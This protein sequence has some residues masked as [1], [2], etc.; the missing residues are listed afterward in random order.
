[1]YEIL[2]RV[3]GSGAP[4]F[5]DGWAVVLEAEWGSD[6]F[7]RRH[8]EVA[9]LLS[10]TIQQILAL[11]EAQRVRYS[12]YFPQWWTAVVQ[13]DLGWSDIGRPARVLVA[14]ETLDHL[15]SA[16]DLLETAMRGSSAAPSGSNLEELAESCRSW[17]EIL[18][19]MPDSEL[20][21]SVRNEIVAQITHLLWL[22]EHAELF[23]VARVSREANVVVGSLTQASTML[24]GVDAQSGGRWKRAFLNL[25]AASV[26]LTAGATQLQ[27][28]IEAGSGVVK[29]ITQVVDGI[30]AE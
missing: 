19:E 12:R 1:M 24:T 22:I 16:A 14:Q 7:A 10:E 17:L 20:G 18:A 15:A 5:R 23:G 25:V 26:V 4:N 8:A 29:E 13:P 28:A 11:P 3:W 6:E 2:S 9:G 27:T 21:S 30:T